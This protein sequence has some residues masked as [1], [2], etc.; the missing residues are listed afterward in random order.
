MIVRI[1]SLV[2]LGM[3]VFVFSACKKKEFTGAAP[4]IT[5]TAVTN[6][7]TSSVTTGGIITHNGGAT[8]TASGIY[9]SRTSN[10]PTIADDTTRGST[11]IGIFSTTLTGLD[12]GATYYVRAYAINKV[13]VGYGNAI[14]FATANAVPVARNIFF[15]GEPVMGERITVRYTYFDEENDPES[16]TIIQWFLTNDTTN[17]TFVTITMRQIVFISRHFL[18]AV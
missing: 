9:W 6:V 15:H 8:V 17:G 5:T 3:S 4:T 13:G 11:S 2:M 1:L 10:L 14:S 7:T 16:G 12:H 18:R